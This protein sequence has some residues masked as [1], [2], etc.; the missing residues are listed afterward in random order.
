[1]KRYKAIFDL[2]DNLIPP[3]TVGFQVVAPTNQPFPNQ[4]NAQTYTAPLM[5]MAYIDIEDGVYVEV[6]KEEPIEEN[7]EE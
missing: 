3:P 4:C 1:M 5:P 2:P 7:K 6:T